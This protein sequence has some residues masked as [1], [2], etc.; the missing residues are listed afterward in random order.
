MNNGKSVV[1]DNVNHTSTSLVYGTGI[2]L[3]KPLF[4]MSF[5]DSVLGNSLGFLLFTEK[6]LTNKELE[7]MVKS[8]VASKLESMSGFDLSAVSKLLG[9]M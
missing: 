8:E 3:E 9:K 6:E 5:D 1:I 4:I 2:Q 7:Y